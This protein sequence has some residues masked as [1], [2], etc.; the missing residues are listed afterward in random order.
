MTPLDAFADRLDRLADAD[1]PL[2]IVEIGAEEWRDVSQAAAPVDTGFMKA[3]TVI[4]STS[5]G[6]SHA[7]AV[8]ES[9]AEYAGFINGGTR[10]IAPRPFFDDG[11]LAAERLITGSLNVKL[12]ASIE[13]MLS[14]GAKNPLR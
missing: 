8:I 2:E 12:K 7:E 9:R 5:G 14:G 10:W 11:M 4:T 13:A 3:N 6:S 1:Y